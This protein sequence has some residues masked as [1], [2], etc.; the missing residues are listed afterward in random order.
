MDGLIL[1]DKPLHLTS[2][3]IVARLRRIL[4]QPKIGH[5]GTLDPSASG[6]L[7]AAAG[8]ATRLFPFFSAMDKAY[9]GKI[10][11]GFATDTYDAAG[12]PS[13]AE[14][15]DW[16]PVSRIEKEMAEFVGDILQVPPP[17][18]AKKLKGKPLY[19]YARRKKPVEL[20]PFPVS[21][22]VFKLEAYEPPL[23]AFEV[24]C[25]S[26]TYIRTLA[27]DLGKRLG[28]GAHLAELMRTE[29]GTF[30]L[31]DALTLEMIEALFERGQPEK[32]LRPMEILLPEF[33]KVILHESGV[34]LVRDGRPV[35]VEHIL[36]FPGR[37][38]PN[39]S[40]EGPPVIRLFDA[41]G[42][43]VALAR[44]AS[45]PALYAPFLVLI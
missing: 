5:F 18:S 27:H 8:K 31:Q 6:L 9:K 24:R 19:D 2:H 30:S 7:I 42:H 4:G 44:R 23:A 21:I 38:L 1:V 39:P 12:Q 28:C 35:P 45:P 25:S 26:G 32:F 13:S 20:R 16:P 10:R 17:F 34:R 33:P 11:M 37:G 15:R 36:S 22:R 3:D 29:I 40:T 41:D 43:L 14:T